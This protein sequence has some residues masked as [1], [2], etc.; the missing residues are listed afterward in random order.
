[1]IVWEEEVVRHFRP[2]YFTTEAW[3]TL[4]PEQ[5]EL[6]RRQRMA[7]V[8]ALRREHEAHYHRGDRRAD[9]L[10]AELDVNGYGR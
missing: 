6:I 4:G 2:R 7:V 5:R 9:D 3:A 10:A 8:E 1:M